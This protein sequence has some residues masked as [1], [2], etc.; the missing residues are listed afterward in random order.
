MQQFDI[1]AVGDVVTDAFIK[2]FD[3]QAK[4]IKDDKDGD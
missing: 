2:L 4:V 3:D 1:L